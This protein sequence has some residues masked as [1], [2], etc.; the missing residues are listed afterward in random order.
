MIWDVITALVLALGLF[1]W[2]IYRGMKRVELD[3]H[4]RH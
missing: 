3:E 2:A 4:H 1:A